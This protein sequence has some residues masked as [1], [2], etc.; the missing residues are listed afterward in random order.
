MPLGRIQEFFPGPE[1][2]S[3]VV[4]VAAFRFRFCNSVE[5]CIVETDGNGVSRL[6]GRTSNSRR[7]NNSCRLSIMLY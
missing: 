2:Q 1:S 5:F 6:S 7:L 4:F 3:L